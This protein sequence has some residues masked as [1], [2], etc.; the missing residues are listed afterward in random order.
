MTTNY[1]ETSPWSKKA[2]DIAATFS[3]LFE[4][5]ITDLADLTG[6]LLLS[7]KVARL[8]ILGSA[9]GGLAKPQY[10]VELVRRVAT[11]S[12]ELQVCQIGCYVEFNSEPTTEEGNKSFLR[13]FPD[14]HTLAAIHAL[15][16]EPKKKQFGSITEKALLKIINERVTKKT[17]HQP[18]SSMKQFC[19]AASM[20]VMDS[21]QIA[22]PAYLARFMTGETSS[23]SI[24]ASSLQSLWG[25]TSSETRSGRT[26]TL[27]S[28]QTVNTH[29]KGKPSISSKSFL[30][31]LRRA[32]RVKDSK[33]Q[34]IQRRRVID[35]LLSLNECEHS[36][37]EMLLLEFMI[38]GV[39]NQG[40]AISSAN[41]YLS[42][43]AGP[44]LTET[45]DLAV[46]KLHSSQMTRLFNLLMKT[47]EKNV[48]AA[49]KASILNQFFAFNHKVFGLELPD[50]SRGQFKSVQ[51]VRNYVISETNFVTLCNE[52]SSNPDHQNLIGEGLVQCLILMARCGLRPSE[53]TKLRIK[54]VEPSAEHYI[55]IRENQ[56][57]TNK[58]YSAR[59]KIPLSIM[60][61]PTEFSFFKR[62]F[63]RRAHE[64][65]AKRNYL[66]F[67]S[68]ANTNLPYTLA[69]FH[70]E[71]SKPLTR[72]C[73]E[74]V[75][76]YHLR[77]KAISVFQ[78]V[79]CSSLLAD[80]IPYEKAQIAVIRKYFQTLVGRDVIYQI[81]TFAGHLSPEITFHNYM[82]FTDTVL[83][84]HLTKN[85]KS[86]HRDYWESLANVSKHIITRRCATEYPESEEMQAVLIELL[87]GKKAAS[88]LGQERATGRIELQLRPRKATYQECLS[89]LKSL[90]RGKTL[91]QVTVQLG[92]DAAQLFLWYEI[93]RELAGLS[94]TKGSPRLFPSASKNKLAP[95]PPPS[96]LEQAK[97]DLIIESARQ[98]Y[99]NS[100]EALVWLVRFV[101][102]N[103]MNSHSYIIFNDIATFERFMT[104]ASQLTIP[105][106]W[107]I[108]LDPPEEYATDALKTWKQADKCLTISMS[109]NPV[110]T[111][112]FPL[113]RVY[114][115]FLYPRDPSEKDSKP[116]KSSNGF[117]YVCH[118]L[119][120]MIPEVFI[121]KV[122]DKYQI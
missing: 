27:E 67:P 50:S 56:Y 96:T 97:A 51:N 11:D 53:V 73:G 37:A 3:K 116:R 23:V 111:R 24:S 7:E 98:L 63:V 72:I 9:R 74:A 61:L 92:V 4:T 21:A 58:T 42:H 119:A 17:M 108:R 77:H 104:V 18:F 31:R 69:D 76:T 82:H 99:R 122:G 45:N 57:G 38:H 49:E 94:T 114:V 103:A 95:I 14:P 64:V 85:Q 54:D 83:F 59:R 36:L 12:V 16:K 55:F 93:A 71:F 41:T 100:K 30:S 112:K 1:R 88:K 34:L 60:L 29:I 35:E 26:D 75:Y 118:L 33:G 120:I 80:A 28:T 44:W 81:A 5:S 2:F 70:R 78:A 20:F 10:L 15:V 43:I 101:V 91:T 106:D 19:K 62:Y 117:K 52:V 66:L 86:M 68:C 47:S 87:C 40:W 107:K 110:K 8:V 65:G 22:L 39:R 6:F 89:A 105:E 102:T 13:W 46:D 115:H 121:R 79:L 48:S 25:A 109:N 90:E 32:L 113:G 84:E